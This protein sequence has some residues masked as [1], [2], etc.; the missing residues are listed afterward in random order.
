MP[1]RID[2]A[3]LALGIP[4]AAATTVVLVMSLPP[5]P[6]TV[7]VTGG[8]VAHV[9]L[10]LRRSHPMGAF[11]LVT[12]GMWLLGAG[13]GLALVLPSALTF[14]AAVHAVAAHGPA[15]GR[16]VVL[17]VTL[18]SAGLGTW[19][20]V[21]DPSLR[22]QGLDPSAPLVLALLLAV[23][24]VAW[25]LGRRARAERE[26][27]RALLDRARERESAAAASER[28]RIATEMHDVI[29]HSLSTVVSQAKGGQFAGRSD[30]D[31]ALRALRTIEESGRDA[32]Q[33]LRALLGLLQETGSA[34]SRA[35]APTLADLPALVSGTARARLLEEGIARPMP[36]AWQL[37]V[38]RVVQES[39]T[40]VGK[41]AGDA[42]RTTVS[43]SW[44]TSDLEVAVRDTG[45]PDQPASP[46][47]GLGQG[48]TGMRHRASLLGG[49][50]RS[51]PVP[52]GGYEVVASLPYPQAVTS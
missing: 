12:A 35:P 22:A 37:A 7:A 46:P 50:L 21:S 3:A 24:L 23:L 34:A 31:A 13:S 28:A 29:A 6:A 33:E 45:S 20:L 17:L 36:M 27:A 25:S 32:A 15:R 51:G 5:L 38:Y 42:A 43:L 8:L 11:A 48:L 14:P 30:P 47:D 26:R 18:P 40:N 49:R 1:A 9:G 4:L 39:L 44:G 52:T 2:R 10:L 41:H 16:A 19:R